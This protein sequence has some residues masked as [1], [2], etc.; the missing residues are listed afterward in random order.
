MLY[1]SLM[2]C[3]RLEHGVEISCRGKQ[4]ANTHKARFLKV[5]VQLNSPPNPFSSVTQVTSQTDRQKDRQTDRQHAHPLWVMGLVNVE[6]PNW[7]EFR[8]LVKYKNIQIL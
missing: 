3:V 6:F 4:N 5:A 7:L 2:F 1:V 8:R